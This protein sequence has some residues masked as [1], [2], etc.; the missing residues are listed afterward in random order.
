MRTLSPPYWNALFSLRTM[1]DPV[2]VNSMFGR[3]ARRYDLANVLLSFG[4]DRYWRWRLMR[5]VR[6]A[7]PA[8]I[9]DLATGSGDVAEALPP[10]PP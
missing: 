5:A 10:S 2:A 7:Q 8:E 1:P 3:I 4:I 9:L 6:R